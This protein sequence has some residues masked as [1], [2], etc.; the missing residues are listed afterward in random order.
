MFRSFKY[1]VY[2]TDQQ[3]SVLESWLD[4]SRFLWNLGHEQRLLNFSRPKGTRKAVNYFNQCAELT[5]LRSEHAWIRDM[6]RH[7]SDYVFRTLDSSWQRYF[8]KLST[9]PKFKPKNRPITSLTEF[10][11]TYFHLKGNL[12]KFPKLPGIRTVVHRPLEGKAKTCT[13][14]KD[15][16]RWYV[17]ITCEIEH[18]PPV[19]T[20]PA[21][22]IDRGITNFIGDSNGQLVPN[23]K[24]LDTELCRLRRAQQRLS[25][26]HKGSKNRSKAVNRVSRIHRRIRNKRDHFLHVL[27]KR[28]VDNQGTVVIEKL[29]VAGMVRSN[30]GRQIGQVAWSKFAEMLRYKLEWS[31]GQL[32]EVPAH[33]T[34]Q[35]CSRCGHCDSGNRKQEKFECTKCGYVDH[36]D[37]NA[38]T[39]I[40]NRASSPVQP[41][42]SSCRLKT[43]RRSRK[44]QITKCGDL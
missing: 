28:I 14:K 31:G 35:T 26:R 6:P 44:S 22:G 30:L 8:E 5:D 36:A 29:N 13:I 16:D 7:V 1:R 25:R 21:I 12:L 33:Y 39:N 19:N 15:G 4:T 32:I 9:K 20:K 37:I 24:F 42:E 3:R 40:F 27:S 43:P 41:V 18:Q 17:I 38:A 2:P 34:S 10:D 11:P 23:P